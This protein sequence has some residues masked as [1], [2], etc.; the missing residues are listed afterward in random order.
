MR[1]RLDREQMRRVADIWE[2]LDDGDA[3]QP[4]ERLFAL[5]CDRASSELGREVDDGDVADALA[6]RNGP[7]GAP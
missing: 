3:S 2:E 4:T 1:Q 7:K 5:V 6:E